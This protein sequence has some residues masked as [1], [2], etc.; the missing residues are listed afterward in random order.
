VLQVVNE[1]ME[2]DARKIVYDASL[3]I[4]TDLLVGHQMKDG[5]VDQE[6]VVDPRQLVDLEH[7]EGC[8]DAEV[9]SIVVALETVLQA[10]RL[11]GHNDD[12]EGVG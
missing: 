1:R 6:Q 11:V 4:E 10:D 8:S 7:L 3:A 2:H 12:L 9:E 5:L